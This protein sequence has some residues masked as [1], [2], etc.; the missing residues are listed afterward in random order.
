MAPHRPRVPSLLL[1]PPPPALRRH[2]APGGAAAGPGRRAKQ[3]GGGPEGPRGVRWD[4]PFRGQ[5]GT[6][7]GCGGGGWPAAGTAGVPFLARTRLGVRHRAR[8]LLGSGKETPRQPGG[9]HGS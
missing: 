2:L 7:R 3:R 1:P 5:R 6:L 4:R 9:L 8:Q